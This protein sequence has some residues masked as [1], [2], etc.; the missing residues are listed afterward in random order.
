MLQTLYTLVRSL[1]PRVL[2]AVL[3]VLILAGA[4]TALMFVAKIWGIYCTPPSERFPSGATLIVIR[5]EKEPFLNA[6]DRPLPPVIEEEPPPARTM[7]GSG[8]I[9]K[10]SIEERVIVQLPYIKLLHDEAK[11]TSGTM[12]NAMF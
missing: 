8:P 12:R 11:D 2:K 6:S 1:V 3:T 10:R 4:F 9:K 5:G 7:W